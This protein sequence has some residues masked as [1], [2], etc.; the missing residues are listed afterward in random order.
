MNEVFSDIDAP[1]SFVDWDSQLNVVARPSIFSQ[2]LDLFT[3]DAIHIYNQAVPLLSSSHDSES[4]EPDATVLVSDTSMQ[5][6][7]PNVAPRATQ[8][9]TSSLQPARVC[10]QDTDSPALTNELSEP[11]SKTRSWR[12]NFSRTSWCSRSPKPVTTTP[13]RQMT[14]QRWSLLTH[15]VRQAHAAMRQPYA[16]PCRTF[17]PASILSTCIAVLIFAKILPQLLKN[18][19]N[20][21][22]VTP[23][24]LVTK[25]PFAISRRLWPKLR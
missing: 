14:N 13:N 10:V 2:A 5:N 19:P 21:L 17:V 20:M 11:S 24:T 6:P 23:V 4:L 9:S 12:P 3:A 1:D 15:R 22:F 8:E 16:N 7:V 25:C 18:N